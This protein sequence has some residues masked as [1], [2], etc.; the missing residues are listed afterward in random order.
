MSYPNG[1]CLIYF[2]RRENGKVFIREG[3]IFKNIRP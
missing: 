1:Y 3:K 2:L